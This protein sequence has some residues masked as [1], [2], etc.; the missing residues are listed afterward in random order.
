M[1]T[2]GFRIGTRLR[3]GAGFLLLLMA[4]IAATAAYDA[5]NIVRG[6][7]QLQ[8]YNKLAETA[9]KW[10]DNNALN[11][12]RTYNLV[13]SKNQADLTKHLKPLMGQIV[14][15]NDGL[16]KVM[17]EQ[18]RSEEA[19]RAIEDIQVKRKAFQASR[20]KVFDALEAQQFDE[21]K[22]LQDSLM[23][24]AL[25]TFRDAVAGFVKL[26]NNRANAYS[27]YLVARSQ[28]ALYQLGGLF[29]LAVLA[30]LVSTALLNRSITQPLSEVVA[31]ID[32]V[33]QGD[34][35]REMPVTRQDELGDLQ[36]S[37]QHMQSHLTELVWQVQRSAGRIIQAADEVAHGT[38][39]LSE[40]T[41]STAS[42]LEQTAASMEEFTATSQ[43]NM[44]SA[45]KADE[46]ARNA[47]EVATKS[48]GSVEHVT[49]SMEQIAKGSRRISEVIGVIDSI[50]FQTNILALNAAVEAARAGESGRGFAVV[51]SEVRNLAQRSA[52][53]ANEIKA[54]ISASVEEVRTGSALVTETSQ[55][56]HE[57]ADAVEQVA[58]TIASVTVASAE[59]T[60]GIQQVNQAV[61]S[62]DS[63]TQQNAALVE[64]ASTAAESLKHQAMRLN[65]L[66]Q[67]FRLD[68]AR[69]AE[70]ESGRMTKQST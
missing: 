53:A 29:A 45:K 43:Q 54:L 4:L 47:L 14:A 59:Q 37:A 66:A 32:A 18:D 19:V 58:T 8:Q 38:L 55:T 39:D 56:M 50:A 23:V 62:L 40:R 16:L 63:M 3:A 31:S 34:M 6:V 11:N 70:L 46:L 67:R 65:D 42:N 25:N 10:A 64:T 51:A 30:G 41:E 17:Q 61:S 1:A 33:A 49:G 48:R 69:V 22:T 35:T 52:E 20:K 36:R 27:D 21:A 68:P 13:V 15:E 57:L 26:Q 24:P 7:E 5:W 44:A 2:Q 12:D 60:T 9:R 28:T